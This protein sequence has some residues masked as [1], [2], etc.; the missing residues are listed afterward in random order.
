MWP[1]MVAQ[2]RGGAGDWPPAGDSGS[3]VVQ[4]VLV[5][6]N[7]KSS[8]RTPAEQNNLPAGMSS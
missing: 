3:W 7:N 6:I 2:L 1:V 4:V 5:L 8:A